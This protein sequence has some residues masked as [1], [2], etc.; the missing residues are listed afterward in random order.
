L[1]YQHNL[2]IAEKYIYWAT[3][4]CRHYGSIFI[5]LAIV[6]FQNREIT[7]NSDKISPYSSSR[8]SKV[9]DFGVNRK[10]ICDFLLVINSTFGPI[11]YRF[12]A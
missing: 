12:R 11:C 8:S 4:F 1:H 6:A 2:Y 5:H 10:L 7:R 3:I 9:I